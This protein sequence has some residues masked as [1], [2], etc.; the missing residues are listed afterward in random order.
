MPLLEMNNLLDRVVKSYANPIADYTPNG[1]P[2]KL[3]D[4]PAPPISSGLTTAQAVLSSSSRVSAKA[5]F[6]SLVALTWQHADN[7]T[8]SF[9]S[10]GIEVVRLKQHK[11]TFDFFKAVPA[12]EQTLAKVIPV[13]R[14]AYLVV[15]L[16]IWRAATFSTGSASNKSTSVWVML[17]VGAALSAVASWIQI[18]VVKIECLLEKDGLAPRTISSTSQYL[19]RS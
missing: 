17:P 19:K 4:F 5:L 8:V 9:E 12:V 18:R 3:I 14:K 15:E 7:A 16:L 1:S 13:G 6:T 10:E 11:E 2:Q